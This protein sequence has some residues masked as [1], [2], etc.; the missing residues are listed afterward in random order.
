M[1]YA[2]ATLTIGKKYQDMFD[3]YFRH[4]V[5]TYCKKY[6]IDLI[7]INEPIEPYEGRSELCCQK[8][9]I[10][11]MEWAKKYDAICVID[12]DILISPSAENIFNNVVDD[13][14]LFTKPDTYGD[15]FYSWKY[16]VKNKLVKYNYDNVYDN[17][18]K[19]DYLKNT[20]LYH[21]S[22]DL[23]NVELINEGV[24]VF[25]PK[26]HGDYLKELY[27]THKNKTK[28]S[29]ENGRDGTFLAVGEIWWYYK[30]MLDNKHKFIDHRYNSTWTWYRRIHLEPFDDP[31]NIIIP[32]KNYIDNS[33]FCHIGDREYIDLIHFVYKTYFM[34]LD[35]TLVVKCVSIENLNWIFSSYIRAKEFK[36][37]FIVCKDDSAKHFFERF[38]PR[39]QYVNFFPREIYKFVNKVPEI[40]G[41]IIECNSDWI[42][43]KEFQYILELFYEDKSENDLIKVIY[44]I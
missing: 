37:V 25:Q 19:I 4:S 12:S 39:I 5:E 34:K 35:T 13:K 11:S 20:N 6:N 40:T 33:Y 30:V 28:E 7:N 42:N 43:H 15:R 36:D 31:Q 26:F 44:N 8:I 10:P 3:L 23:S 21:E 18:H 2:I 14:I 16:F 38:Y 17:S 22:H 27:K 24:V 9:L 41:R 32:T 1:K 29:N